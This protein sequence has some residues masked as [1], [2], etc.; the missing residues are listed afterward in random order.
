M[1]RENHEVFSFVD[2]SPDLLLLNQKKKRPVDPKNSACAGDAYLLA[3]TTKRVRP[4]LDKVQKAFC[5]ESTGPSP[6]PSSLSATEQRSDASTAGVLTN[7][8]EL[9]FLRLSLVNLRLRTSYRTASSVAPEE[10]TESSAQ[11]AF[12]LYLISVSYIRAFM[13]LR[14]ER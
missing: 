6:K 7:R 3:V 14:Q 1:W 4:H 13:H 10:A 8:T 12:T 5:A 9:A 11:W 2:E